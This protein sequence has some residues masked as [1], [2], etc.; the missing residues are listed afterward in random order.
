MGERKIVNALIRTTAVLS[1]AL[2]VAIVVTIILGHH[3][4]PLQ[5]QQPDSRSAQEKNLR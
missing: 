3:A 2:A 5:A 1:I 4:T